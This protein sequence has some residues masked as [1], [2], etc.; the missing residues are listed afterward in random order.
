MPLSEYVRRFWRFCCVACCVAAIVY[1]LI[2]DPSAVLLFAACATVFFVLSEWRY[3][4]L[5]DP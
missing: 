3:R 4:D 5:G 2:H 1:M